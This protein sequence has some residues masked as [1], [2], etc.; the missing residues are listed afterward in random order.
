MAQAPKKTRKSS[1]K[2]TDL[3]LPPQSLEAEQTL[4]G[5]IFLNNAALPR[6]LETRLA[7]DDFYREAHGLIF[8]AM[9]GHF[10]QGEPV[11]LVT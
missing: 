5:A 4:L 9:Q 10:D 2:T 8:Q 7:P 1:P 3:K 6:V 11:D